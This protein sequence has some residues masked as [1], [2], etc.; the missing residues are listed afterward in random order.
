M[1]NLNSDNKKSF[2]LWGNVLLRQEAKKRG[3]RLFAATSSF[4]V[5]TLTNLFAS[6]PS[7]SQNFQ[8]VDMGCKTISPPRT[9]YPA[10]RFRA[11]KVLIGDREF[12]EVANFDSGR[13]SF[14]PLVSKGQKIFINCPIGSG[15]NSKFRSIRLELG[16]DSRHERINPKTVVRVGIVFDG[17][18]V[19][20]RNIKPGQLTDTYADI[21]GKKNI[22]L[23]V[24]CIEDDGLGKGTSCPGVSF[25][26][27]T[28][29]TSPVKSLNVNSSSSTNTVLLT[30]MQ[31]TKGSGIYSPPLLAVLPG[32]SKDPEVLYINI[33]RQRVR[34][35]AM[36]S[37]GNSYVTGS[38]KQDWIRSSSET[39]CAT[40]SYFQKLNLG[41]GLDDKDVNKAPVELSIYI[42]GQLIGKRRV[43]PGQKPQSW[44]IPLSNPNSINLEAKCIGNQYCPR[45]SFTQLNLE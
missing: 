7:Q 38:R 42:N 15:N 45:L 43:A 22:G 9:D 10:L 12:D 23:T 2:P 39:S 18:I 8:L 5:L 37:S 20:Y 33:G 35:V 17:N 36:L 32:D 14:L 28:L 24:E 21:T 3:E 4:L 1:K 34:E 13:Y 27:M 25:T 41:F 29:S 6:L 44:S 16:L 40:P 26:N 30:E 19:G 31:C 11:A